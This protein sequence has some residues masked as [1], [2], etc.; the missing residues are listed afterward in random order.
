[1]INS[2]TKQRLLILTSGGDSPGMNAVIRATVRSGIYYGLQVFACHNGYQGLV[3]EDIFPMDVASVAN[4]IQRGGTILKT[5]RCSAFHKHEVREKC[6]AFLAEQKID[7]LVVIGGDG[8]FRGGALLEEEGGPKVIGIPGSIDNDIVGTEYTIGY[9]TACNT[10]LS[11]IDKIRDTA[12]S[13]NR[14]FLI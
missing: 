11:A 12:S 13:H 7:F 8:T 3:N 5:S 9:D 6:R 1:M 14:Y 4:C 2:A 10:A